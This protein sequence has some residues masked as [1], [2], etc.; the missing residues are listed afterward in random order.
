MN[1]ACLSPALRP[2]KALLPETLELGGGELVRHGVGFV[3]GLDILLH[4]TEGRV[5]VFSQHFAVHLVGFQELSAPVS[6]AT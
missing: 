4:S 3:H 1:N 5:N 2:S 6:V